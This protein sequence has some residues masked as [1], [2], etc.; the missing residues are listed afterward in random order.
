MH[1]ATIAT[2]LQ[3]KGQIRLL[4]TSA[5]V[6]IIPVARGKG[7]L[8]ACVYCMFRPYSGIFVV[9]PHKDF[10]PSAREKWGLLLVFNIVLAVKE[11]SSLCPY[12][13]QFLG[14]PAFFIPYFCRFTRV[15]CVCAYNMHYVCTTWPPTF[16]DTFDK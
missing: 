16:C 12:H 6:S 7:W 11:M 15:A 2:T 4:F 13:R 8:P 5:S 3:R 10:C 1:F 14:Y 9:I